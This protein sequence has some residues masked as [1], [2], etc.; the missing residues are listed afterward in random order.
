MKNN[1]NVLLYYCYSNIDNP[2]EFRE[3]HHLFCIENNLRGRII[4]S[5]EGINGTV[6]GKIND[7]NKYIKNLKSD[8][9][10]QNIEFKIDEHPSHVFNKLNVRLKDEIVNFGIKTVNPN[11]LSGKYIEPNEFKMVLKNKPND[12]I[13]LDVRSNYEHKVGKFKNALALDINNFRDF[14]KNLKDLKIYKKNKIITYCTGGVKCE[15]ASAFLLKKGFENVYQLH[16]GIIKYGLEEHGEDF[17][18]KCYVFDNR[19]AINVNKINPSTISKCYLTGEPS[20]RMVNCANPECNIHVPMSKKGA[21]IFNGCCSESCENNKKTRK[22]NGTGYYQKKI[23]GYNPYIGHKN[24]S[25]LE[26]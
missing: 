10:F 13:I 16:G 12:T 3:N 15:K 21:R 11:K 4:I 22:Y 26:N 6:S 9:R 20:D 14:K 8:I 17:D 24:K 25:R 19:I 5:S 1:Y 2:D 7:C 23:N 18:G